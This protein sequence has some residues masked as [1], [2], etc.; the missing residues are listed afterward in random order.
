MFTDTLETTVH[1]A[2]ANRHRDF[3]RFEENQR[4][5]EKTDIGE[6]LGYHID[7]TLAYEMRDGAAYCLSDTK[8]RPFHDQTYEA[9]E[10]G[11]WKFTG[12]N[13]FEAERLRLEHQ[14]ALTV[15]AFG[16][17][18]L[19]GNVLVKVSKIPDAVVDG[20][21]RVDGYRRDLMRSFVRL[22]YLTSDNSVACCLFSLDSNSK[23]GFENIERFVGMTMNER[24][25][26]AVLADGTV[27]DWQ[28]DDLETQIALFKEK[29]ILEYDKGVYEESGKKT[30]A[31]ADFS[32]RSNA[33]Q[34]IDKHQDL[35]EE[36]WQ[37]VADSAVRVL[38]AEDREAFLESMRR[39]TAAAIKL[40]EIG[41]A[42]GSIGDASVANEAET[43]QYGRECATNGMN[44]AE[45]DL[46]DDWQRKVKNCPLCG[47][48]NVVA[49]KAGET[50]SG[51]CGCWKNVCTGESYTAGAQLDSFTDMMQTLFSKD[52][53]ETSDYTLYS[54][55]LERIKWIRA[56][57]GN[58]AEERRVV[59]AGT[60]DILVTDRRTG[61]ILAQ[62]N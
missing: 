32:D 51:S 7:H 18:E 61:E 6:R 35:F 59:R 28:S 19:S 49:T 36:H 39:K 54:H 52:H 44:Q 22:Y 30:Y 1:A 56:N 26:E 33:L 20:T 50:I 11:R 34:I 31:G 60:Q 13:A 53:P 55:S 62:L 12:A 45:K 24:P 4:F 17:G 5:E 27:F 14:E 47:R 37:A 40:R 29:I 3:E 41:Q 2:R 58:D 25:S 16:R 15:D 48:P 8:E 46:L 43:G 38:A 21:A 23:K 9:M 10:A 42:V 57:F